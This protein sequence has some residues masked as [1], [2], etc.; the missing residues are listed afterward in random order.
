[1][2]TEDP[3]GEIRSRAYSL[4]TI[5]AVDGDKHVI[6]GIA[7][8]PETDRMGDIVDPLGAKF[9]LPMPLLWQHDSRQPIGEV[10]FAKPTKSGIPFKAKIASTDEPG[11]LKDRLDEAW[12][13]IKLGLVK[14]VSIGFRGIEHSVMETGGWRFTEWEWLETSVV[15]I[16]ANASATI[17]T[18]KSISASQLAAS[19]TVLPSVP[20]GVTGKP[21]KAKEAK[22]MSK[23]TITEQIASF[24]ATRASKDAELN[25][26]MDDAA[27]KSETLDAEQKEAYDNLAAEVKEI[28]EHLVRL[29][30]REAANKAK[31]VEVKGNTPLAAVESRGTPITVSTKRMIP[32]GIGFVR[33]M[34]AKWLGKQNQRD[35]A[36]IA[37]SMWPDMP[38][39]EMVLRTPVTAGT[40]TDT[41][42]AAPL[43][44]ADNLASEFV[45]LL[46]PAT[47]IGRIPGLTRVPFNV[48]IPRETTGASVN[49]VGEG[50]IKPVSSMAFD[51]ITMLFHKVAGIVP[52]TQELMRFSN[53]AAEGLIRDSLIKAIAYLTD[54]D[55]LDP[56][57]ALQTGVSPAS[58]TNG[59]TPI[60]A[61]GITSA[62]LLADLGSLITAYTAANYNISNLVLIMSSSQAWKIGTMLNA[63]GQNMF[64]GMGAGGGTLMGVTV[65]TSENLVAAG[66]SPVDGSIIVALSAPDVLLADDGGVTI[67]ASTEASIQMDTTPDS[68]ATASTV[69]VSAFQ[70]NMVFI[71]AERFVTWLKRRSDAVQYINGAKY[72]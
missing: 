69:T 25:K 70:Y 64:P 66:G 34:G 49:W 2:P 37:K 30:A 72:A 42:W 61:T 71:R 51:S 19:G 52:I 6:E 11:R 22:R 24:E 5:K 68:P 13:S 46:V 8:T 54:R 59:V 65:V 45:S 41:T 10:F 48:K 1:M 29:R 43:V 7:S 67:D 57:K 62:A 23:Q 9:Q 36:D 3:G 40:T 55:F 16:P 32:P 56:A 33:L 31:A 12:Q 50:A 18:V 63:L 58:I 17:E 4:L 20:P 35:P 38:E 27:E 39:L 21:V 14:A 44:V 28:D 60:Q 53:P 15:T 47:I 26:I